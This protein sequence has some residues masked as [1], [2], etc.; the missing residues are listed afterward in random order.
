MTDLL[1]LIESWRAARRAAQSDDY[2]AFRA[3][4]ERRAKQY[5]MVI[6]SRL[7]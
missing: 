3:D 5:A 1:R 2:R 4:Y 7:K 6:R